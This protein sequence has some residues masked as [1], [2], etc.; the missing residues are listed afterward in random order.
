MNL[1]DTIRAVAAQQPHHLA[2]EDG[3]GAI[4]YATLIERIDALARELRTM[5]C[6]TLALLADNSSDWIVF[7]LACLAAQITCIPLP[8]FFSD[9]Q[10]RNTLHASGA[11]LIASDDAVRIA[12]ITPS[13]QLEKTL[14]RLSVWTVPNAAT[15]SMPVG[16][17]KITF[18]SGSSGT[19]KGVCLSA[20]AQFAVAS[21]LRDVTADIKAERHFSVLP[22]ATLLEN[23]AGIYLP[24]LRGATIVAL[25]S[26]QIGF[27]GARLEQPQQFLQALS[28]QQPNS[29]IVLPQF[30]PLLIHAARNGWQI[31][32]SLQFIAVGGGKV[33]VAWLHAV[34]ALGLPVYEGYGLSECASVVALNTP[35][36][37]CPGMVGRVLPHCKVTIEND[38]I[39]VHG[40]SYLGYLD[41]NGGSGET[42]RTADTPV[43]TG[44]LGALDANGFL[45]IAG[46]SKNLLISSYGRNISPEW[47]ETELMASGLFRHCVVFGDAQPFCVALLDPLP[48]ATPIAIA[49]AM[50]A[51]NRN[52]PEYAQI[53]RWHCLENSLGAQPELLTANG[54]PRRDAIAA[55]YHDEINSLYSPAADAAGA[56]DND[57]L[58]SRSA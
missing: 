50:A 7:D 28:E 54:R 51:A 3:C 34:R 9:A 46:R 32:T 40:N 10:L 58:L 19:P 4:T 11:D 12:Q 25:P 52:L 6:K 22:Y 39:V 33:P 43:R 20:A 45:A 49:A 37:D 38:E 1:L 15:P 5:R 56:G 29:L 47:P 18:T 24:L 44:D 53:K 13:A 30:L 27:N 8:G 57:G 36:H 16:T 42:P 2:V 21:G 23:I 17:D 31:P 35:G 48:H 55:H 41:V 26:A 14:S